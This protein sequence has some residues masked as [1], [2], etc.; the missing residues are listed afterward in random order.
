MSDI[1]RKGFLLGLGVAVSG[2]ERVE[3]VLNDLVDKNELTQEQAKSVLNSLIEKGEAKASEWDVKQ[4]EQTRKLADE[5]GFALKEDVEKLAAR[6]SV[7]EEKL[8]DHE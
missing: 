6:I 5:L 4:H 2:K 7:L 8:Y 3:K 1:L